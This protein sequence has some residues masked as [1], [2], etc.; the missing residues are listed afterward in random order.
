MTYVYAVMWFAVGLILIFRMSKENRIFY[1]AGA[2]FI[3]LGGWWL[4][5][6]MGAPNMF[7]GGWGWALRWITAVALLLVCIVFFKETKK[8]SEKDKLEKKQK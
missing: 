5:S 6:A 4:A 2:F 3:L 1:A 8:S 7:T